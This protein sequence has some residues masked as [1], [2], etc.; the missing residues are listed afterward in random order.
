MIGRRVGVLLFVVAAAGCG[1]TLSVD[2][3]AFVDAP[4][5]AKR[6]HPVPVTAT[7]TTGDCDE[8]TWLEAAVDEPT[9]VVTLAGRVQKPGGLAPCST[10]ISAKPRMTTFTPQSTGTYRI[11]VKL[12][13]SSGEWT[14][15]RF[16][17]KVDPSSEPKPV[18]ASIAVEVSE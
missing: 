10:G 12:W 6:G 4:R 8:V 18:T 5:V 14:Y 15:E 11:R 7:F 9:K 13:P 1:P 2:T 17:P 3:F 16:E